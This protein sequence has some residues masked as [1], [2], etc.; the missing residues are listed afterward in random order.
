MGQIHQ[1][2]STD[3]SFLG[4]RQFTIKQLKERSE[5]NLSLDLLGKKLL[6]G[7]GISSELGD[8]LTELLNTHGLLVEV[9]AEVSLVVEVLAL[10]DLEAG[11][12]S[13]VELLGHGIGGVEEV[14]QEVGG[15]G[16]VVTT[17]QLS[18]LAD[19][20]ERGTHDNGVVAEL[21]VVVVDVLD[22]LDTGVLLGGV[23]ALVGSLEPVKNATNEGRDEVGTG[24]SGGNGLNQREHKGQVAVNAV[25]GLE[26][27]SGLD[28]LV[29]GGNLDQDTVLGDTVV[30]VK[31]GEKSQLGIV[32]KSVRVTL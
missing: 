7:N 26:D 8:T 27:V 23:V 15:D 18:D 1:F 2:V 21:L 29:G 12:T 11:G 19:V 28:A 24:L 14:L 22:R 10:L 9:E 16:Q 25:L 30:G 3:S 13:G 6:E 20:T 5:P 32:D 4:D 17:S 31:L